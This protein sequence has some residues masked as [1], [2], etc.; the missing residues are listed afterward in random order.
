VARGCVRGIPAL[1][2]I[3][4][5][6][7]VALG[8]SLFA[9]EISSR[10]S[11]TPLTP[12]PP[13]PASAR[14]ADAQNL[15]KQYAFYMKRALDDNN[16]REALKQGSLMLGELR[17]TALSPQK[18]YELY[19]QVWSELHHL[20]SFF[21][22]PA[23]HGRT[24]LELYEL[25]QHAGNILPRL[26]LLVTVGSVYVKSGEG[27]AKDVLKDLVEMAKGVQHPIHGLFLRAYL[28]QASKT[29]LPD[30][31]SPFEGEG[32]DTRDA[33]DFVLQNFTEMNKLWVRMAH[34]GPARDVDRREKERRELRDLVGKNLHV[35]SSLEGLDL[36][37]YRD[38]VLPRVLE[39]VVQC[40][41]D[42]AQ[43]YLMDAVT[44]VFPDDFH[45]KTLE[46]L[47]GAVPQ[48]KP[49]VR[50]GDVLAS[51][52]DRLTQA[53]IDAPELADAFADADAL[54]KFREC[55]A[56]VVEAQP[57]LEARERLLMH[58][59]LMSF[60]VAAH[61]DRLE[62]VDG[63]L[64]SCASALG[65]PLPPASP[66]DGAAGEAGTSASSEPPPPAM[67][68]ADPKAVKQLVA[69][70]TVPLETYDTDDVL[71]LSSY[72][73]CMSL[74]QPADARDMAVAVVKSVL[75]GSTAVGD[76]RR[77]E[78]LFKFVASLMRD[79]GE[80]D[81]EDFEEA[82]LLMSRLVHRLRSDDTKTQL[83]ILTT[84]KAQ[85][86]TGGAKRLRHAAPPLAFEALRL[87]RAVV[88]EQ[89]LDESSSTKTHESELLKQVL[90][91]LYQLVSNLEQ[92]TCHD[93]A[94]RLCLE[95][96]RLADSAGAE[97]AAGDLFERAMTSYEEEIVDSKKQ[98]TALSL[99]V[100]SLRTCENFS[101]ETR[102]ELADRAV[103]YAARLLKKTD[104]VAALA[105]CAHLHWRKSP[106]KTSGEDDEGGVGGS[107][108]A[109]GVSVCLQK[110]LK[111]AN[112][113]LQASA[114]TGAGAGEATGL[115]VSVLN[116]YLWFFENGCEGAPASAVAELLERADA[117]LS[118]LGSQGACPPDV[119]A[120]YDAT[121]RHIRHQRGRG[122]VVGARFRDL[123][124]A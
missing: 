17:T 88:A 22:D 72:P 20:E 94:L 78:T 118:Q 84:A 16:L 53:A 69:L 27:A 116:S 122:G 106:A 24:N 98:R 15:V 109:A 6:T 65:A 18:Y 14:A 91:F 75:K 11:A 2:I 96:A 29:L 19:M 46:T 120:H 9:R 52:M 8:A 38:V 13:P 1:P 37:L 30:A 44:Q 55:V 3:E 51:L 87:G 117:E 82:Q 49:S 63:I 100:G 97:H 39:Q 50:A 36:S 45:L 105:A 67:I 119:R 12:R 48:L 4:I 68:V 61:K 95:S 59:S 80:E 79:A 23:R 104:R 43:P 113:S 90:Q 7:R 5:E 99:I 110:A 114:T 57:Q 62:L 41:D 60:A 112:A 101:E 121:V 83:A 111:I 34:G 58:A 102:V 92:A 31:G 70:L 10:P 86:A 81:E 25:V 123:P 71:R 66:R 77:V 124:E 93:L 33:V 56:A 35:L 76:P 107:G 85:F 74:L 21:A 28:G 89:S 64:A 54:L 40:K 103:G 73:R 26:Y 47:L 32:G 108:D 42:I 115:L